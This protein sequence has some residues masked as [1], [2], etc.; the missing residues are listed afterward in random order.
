MNE[1]VYWYW[2]AGTSVAGVTEINI[3]IDRVYALDGHVIELRESI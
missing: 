2:Y 1:V 3:P